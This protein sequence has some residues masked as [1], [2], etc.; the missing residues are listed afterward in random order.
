MKIIK[1]IILQDTT[2]Y[3]YNSDNKVNK[4][5]NF[6][7]NDK[8]TICEFDYIS[9]F[10]IKKS[11]NYLNDNTSGITYEFYD[12]NFNKIGYSKDQ[13]KRNL[14]IEKSFNYDENNNFTELIIY[15]DGKYPEFKYEFI[16]SK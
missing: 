8:S 10:I 2:I 7:K 6:S 12:K 4:E 13:N 14:Y 5:S 16:Y 9:E 11:C 3:E 15:K 1:S